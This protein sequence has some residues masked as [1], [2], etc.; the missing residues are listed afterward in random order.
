MSSQG[1]GAP[2]TTQ[3]SLLLAEPKL[4]IERMGKSGVCWGHRAP[5]D[6]PATLQ[7]EMKKAQDQTLSNSTAT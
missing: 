2:S 1:Y 5:L 4:T 6:P 3:E 7:P